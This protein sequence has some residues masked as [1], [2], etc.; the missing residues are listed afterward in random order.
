MEVQGPRQHL[1]PGT[2]LDARQASSS[3]RSQEATGTRTRS[4]GPPSPLAQGSRLAPVP[5]AFT[6]CTRLTTRTRSHG[7]T[8]RMRL[9][10]HTRSHDFTPRT[11]LMTRT[12]SH[13]PPSPL[14]RG[15]RLLC[16]SLSRWLCR[17][18]LCPGITGWGPGA[19]LAPLPG[20]GS[21][22]LSTGGQRWV[23]GRCAHAVRSHR[24]LCQ[25]S[26]RST[27]LSRSKR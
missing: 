15:S 17:R 3:P 4:H 11:R 12:L 13:G 7:F 25:P 1:G 5:T 8:P 14:A 26:G 21:L 2:R 23:V 27:L 16:R 10:T 9:T 6:P 22:S 19:R 24:A 18:G 20:S